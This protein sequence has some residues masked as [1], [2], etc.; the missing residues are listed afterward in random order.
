MQKIKKLSDNEARKIAAGEVVERPANIV[1]ELIEN[2]IDA[3]ADIISIYLED[4]GKQLVRVVDN[5][6]GM[7]AEDAKLCFEHHATS[8]IGSVDDLANLNTFGFRGEALSS[9]S[10]ISKV[11][12][13]T[14][15]IDSSSGV[16][17]ELEFGDI[18]STQEVNCL[19]GVDLTIQNIFSNVPARLKFLKKSDTEWRQI[20]QL[21]QAFCISYKNI[22]FKLYHDNNLVYNCP[23]TQDLESRLMQLW[24]HNFAQNLISFS[25]EEKNISVFGLTSNHQ[26]ERYN[27]N[28]IFLFVNGRWIKN[29]NLSKTLVKSYLNILQPGKF[30]AAFIFINL[31]NSEVDINIHPRK[32]EVQFLY[33]KKIENII[34][35]TVKDSL[36]KNLSKQ[37]KRDVEISTQQLNS[38]KAASTTT[39]DFERTPFFES[40]DDLF[41]STFDNTEKKENHFFAA[42]LPTHNDLNHE[43][44]IQQTQHTVFVNHIKPENRRDYNLVGQFK[45]TYIL[46]EK[47]EGLVLVDQHAAHERIMYEI[48]SKKFKDVA[49]VRLI[50]PTS[51]SLSDKDM[52]TI[53]PYLEMLHNYGIE[54]EQFGKNQLIIKSVPVYLKDV[55][56]NDLVNQLIGWIEENSILEK[57]EFL[58]IIN[59]KL[60]AQM[61]CKAAVKAG[62]TLSEEQIY[63]LLDDLS[64][65]E[66]RFCCP[67]G[68]P[69]SW[70][71]GINEIEKK[72]KRKN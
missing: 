8:K 29:Q 12:L 11:I 53:L 3:K 40:M 62:D 49:T 45:K 37:I 24:D 21:F 31:P 52:E 63:K 22:H 50:F 26:V 43:M 33:P 46:L 18:I 61:A 4:A 15:E 1:K 20:V 66:N 7:S 56:L 67:H 28:Q 36:Q 59:E 57:N 51:I 39:F 17:I 38:F 34:Y 72:F 42:T 5:G 10:A 60:Q 64:N 16:K 47:E 44:Q 14:K 2:S 71:I 13:I 54:I 65:T 9:I 32:E 69:T 58:K 70:L 27:R 35:D 30:P 41:S 68:R 48:F 23:P 19:N 25:I 55:Q 6:C